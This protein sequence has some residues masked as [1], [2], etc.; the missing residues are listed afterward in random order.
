MKPIPGIRALMLLMVMFLSPMANA[1]L[2][3]IRQTHVT[4][5]YG[6]GVHN[7][8]SAGYG[9]PDHTL[10]G[11]DNAHA[12][13]LD[14]AKEQALDQAASIGRTRT[15]K[16]C[17]NQ[18]LFATDTKMVGQY[19]KVAPGMNTQE[20]Q[21]DSGPTSQWLIE[22]S[23]N[24]SSTYEVTCSDTPPLPEADPFVQLRTYCA[25]TVVNFHQAVVGTG[26]GGF[27]VP[28]PGGD[29]G[30]C[31]AR[32]EWEAMEHA[33]L[34]GV[35]LALDAVCPAGTQSSGWEPAPGSLTYGLVGPTLVKLDFEKEYYICEAK[36][37][38]TVGTGQVC[39]VPIPA[40]I[41]PPEGPGGFVPPIAPETP[42][43]YPNIPP[44]ETP[45]GYVPPTAP[46]GGFPL[47]PPP[48]S[49]GV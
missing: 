46:L 41:P 8:T 35:G 32:A 25:G 24:V 44:P 15:A 23:V 38:A 36:A 2:T 5:G 12:N 28:N 20:S 6:W 45:G 17:S 11:D 37:E 1:Q 7:G 26:W 9:S 47:I 18:G 48:E 3:V 43:T 13:A 19:T 4:S 10:P 39:C 33:R 21:M 27:S 34:Q 49:P 30:L 29:L 40:S 22:I 42:S 31:R 14:D 16:A